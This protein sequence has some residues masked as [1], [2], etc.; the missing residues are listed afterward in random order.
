MNM[1]KNLILVGAAAVAI[2]FAGETV[3]AQ[4]QQSLQF[5][6]GGDSDANNGYLQ[7]TANST[8]S[9]N[10]TN[11]YGKGYSV[12][13]SL[14][15]PYVSTVVPNL[16]TN[17][18]WSQAVNLWCDRDGSVPSSLNVGYDVYGANASAT[19]IVQ[20][21]FVTVSRKGGLPCTQAG[22][23]WQ[24]SVTLNGTNDVVGTTNPPSLLL[25]GVPQLILNS[26][27]TS[28]AG[29]NGVVKGVWLNGFKSIE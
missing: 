23:S 25:S 4:S 28:N 14:T 15:Y 21:N 11:T 24:F 3:Q 17:A 29:T 8:N 22:N 27:V 9:Y 16:V 6:G 10:T 18:S 1:I 19:N 13:N 5:I 7:I 2:C 20:F 26:V 12:S